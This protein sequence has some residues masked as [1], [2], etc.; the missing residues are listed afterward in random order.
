M[1]IFLELPTKIS[2][3]LFQKGLGNRTRTI[4]FNRTTS[5]RAPSLGF[6]TGQAL[7]AVQLEASKPYG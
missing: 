3:G 7:G 5:E 6:G 1:S 4:V 2:H